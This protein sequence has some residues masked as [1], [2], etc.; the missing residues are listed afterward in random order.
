MEGSADVEHLAFAST[1][2]WVLVSR[3]VGDFAR[4]HS[5]TVAMGRQHAGIV[6]IHQRLRLGVGEE[7]R[8]LLAIERARSLD[9]M[10]DTIEYLS[11]WQSD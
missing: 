1:R 4:L 11:R 6:L 9:Q 5:V 3:N 10:R 2:R 7:L 8:R